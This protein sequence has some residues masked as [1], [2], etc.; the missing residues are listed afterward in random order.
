[1][2]GANLWVLPLL[3]GHSEKSKD[4]SVTVGYVKPTKKDLLA[5]VDRLEA[6]YA[7]DSASNG[8]SKK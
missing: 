1:M 7:K 3:L 2:P 6:Y 5:Q 4:V 8:K